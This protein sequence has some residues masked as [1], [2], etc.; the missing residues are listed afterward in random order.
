MPSKPLA[1]VRQ[2]LIVIAVMPAH[3]AV[4]AAAQEGKSA[5]PK[6]QRVAEAGDAEKPAKFGGATD[7]GTFLTGS[8]DRDKRVSKANEEYPTEQL[9][10]EKDPNHLATKAICIDL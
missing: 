6:A 3:G 8:L 5:P 9:G 7:Y 1:F 10:P 2:F 4:S